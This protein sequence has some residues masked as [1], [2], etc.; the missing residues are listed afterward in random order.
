ML[1]GSKFLCVGARYLHPIVKSA[2][3]VI[4]WGRLKSRNSLNIKATSACF[5][6]LRCFLCCVCGAPTSPRSESSDRESPF[7]WPRR[8]TEFDVAHPTPKAVGHSAAVQRKLSAG[9]VALAVAAFL[10]GGTGFS[11]PRCPRRR[12]CKKPCPRNLLF[13]GLTSNGRLHMVSGSFSKTDGFR[14]V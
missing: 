14:T 7:M 11:C 1:H 12:R 9:S 13:D 8:E 2:F 3:T 10:V 6:N 5:E 4:P